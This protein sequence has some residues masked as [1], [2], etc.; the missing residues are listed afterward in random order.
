MLRPT[1]PYALTK[2][3]ISFW[4]L[5]EIKAPKATARAQWQALW[6]GWDL[7]RSV[8]LTWFDSFWMLFDLAQT[9]S[10]QNQPAQ[11][12][13]VSSLKSR[14][15]F[16]DIAGYLMGSCLLLAMPGCT[17][18]GKSSRAFRVNCW[19]SARGPRLS[20][21]DSGHCG[22]GRRSVFQNP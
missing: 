12:F 13:Q 10:A 21:T 18:A 22:D 15:A 20:V 3:R 7:L 9:R 5:G 14:P 4:C 6:S 16:R 1:L 19:S 11:L 2:T 17:K 8:D